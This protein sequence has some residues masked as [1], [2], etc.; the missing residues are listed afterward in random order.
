M[1][2]IFIFN[3]LIF[4]KDYFT[5]SFLRFWFLF[6]LILRNLLSFI[7]PSILST[8]CWF[9][10][11]LSSILLS[12]TSVLSASILST[13]RFLFLLRTLSISSLSSFSDCSLKFSLLTLSLSRISI[14][15]FVSLW[16]NVLFYIIY[17]LIKFSI[18]FDDLK[19]FS[20]DLSFL[21]ISLV[22]FFPFF[23]KPSIW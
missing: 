2:I 8:F 9:S 18:R 14:D 23:S 13:P 1:D 6:L 10:S 16:V 11:I 19:L 20:V 17:D 12:K 4:R 21:F 3:C 22:I 7:M 15:F 5:K